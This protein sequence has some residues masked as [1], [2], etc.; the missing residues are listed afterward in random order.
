MPELVKEQP[1]AGTQATNFLNLL[2]AGGGLHHH[3]VLR[4]G[5]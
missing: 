4:S 5:R 3:I 1:A 2:H